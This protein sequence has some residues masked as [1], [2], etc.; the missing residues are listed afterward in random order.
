MDSL[1]NFCLKIWIINS[2]VAAPT[3]AVFTWISYT[4]YELLEI[5]RGTQH[6]AQKILLIATI[7]YTILLAILC[8]LN[9][10][11]KANS[12]RLRLDS[13]MSGAEDQNQFMTSINA[14]T[15]DNS[16]HEQE[17]ESDDTGKSDL[18]D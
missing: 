18:V 12:N 11:T 2:A 13:L 5:K 17:K 1:K 6:N 3:L 10:F 14:T 16:I 4:E 9:Q 8:V 15:E 7:L